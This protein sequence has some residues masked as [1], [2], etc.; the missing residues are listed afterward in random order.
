M[1]STMEG[2]L[3][4]YLLETESLLD[5]LDEMLIADEKIG[6]FS[7]DDV[8]EIFRI[9]HTIKGSS[10]MMEFT[11][12]SNIAHHIE[13]MFFFIRDK[14]MDCLSNEQ[15]NEL[16][17]LMFRSEDFLRG[18]L[19][20]VKAGDPLDENIEEF[21]EEI[22]NFLAKISGKESGNTKTASGAG[23]AQGTVERVLPNDPKAIKFIHVFLDQGIGMENLRA[24]MIVNALK[25]YDLDFRYYPSDMDTNSE[26]AQVIVDDGFFLAFEK[27]EV[28]EKGEKVLREQSHILSYEIVDAKKSEVKTEEKENISVQNPKQNKEKE[29]AP[30]PQNTQQKSTAPV[31]QSL[32]SVNLQKLD[33]LND[34]VGEIVI[35]E[36][37]VTSS[38]VLRMLPQESLDNFMK[39]AR[40]L[41][42]LTDDLQDIAMSLRMVSISGVFQKM[43]RI[44][45]DM[46][47]K[48]G[49]D[50]KLTIIGEDTE[51][52]KTIV[53]S[54][55][56]PLMHIVR[57]SMDHGIETTKEER[58]AA[59]KDAQGE[60][61]LSASHTSSEVIITVEDDGYGMNP[62]KL[63]D[64]A[65]EKGLLYKPRSEYSKKEA[66]G[67][68]ML[69]GFSTNKS[70]TEFS[71]RGVGM[72]VVK[73]NLESVGGAI[74]ISSE[75]GKGSTFTMKIPL[76]LAIMDGMKVN[77]GDT[78]FTIP[79]VNIRQSFKIDDAEVVFDENG[80]EM[81]KRM[82][83][84]YPIVRLNN[85]YGIEGKYTDLADGVLIWVE[86]NDKSCCLFVDDLIGEQ[87]VVVKPLPAYF[88]AF[89]LKAN[90]I[91]GCSILGDGN[92]CI[93]LDVLG[94]YSQAIENE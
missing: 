23:R 72:D 17:D 51:V 85:F 82:D 73:K 14:G 52:D 6:D 40:Q 28:L 67:L 10:A 12:I 61:I 7:S 59:G 20:K 16:F 29:A 81:V 55:Q 9:M 24:F 80:N 8:N 68:I 70:V 56:D 39:S 57:N 92:I 19:E 54:L 41:R 48:L 34:L 22:N 74:S 78:I 26:T 87:Q 1:D 46:K 64:K 25:E 15:K 91:N 47:Q 84:F 32:I 66:L 37:M 27:E 58:I 35:T 30:Q 62:E 11:P 4:T 89:D 44:V 77:V 49:K 79:I 33:S 53:D 5:K 42:K 13:D 38:P 50:V 3:D 88:N 18:A 43:N 69:P 75:L 21:A 76:T 36:S 94:L 90:G 63:L 2:M 65:E 93:I 31:K 45:R 83:V 86:A 60:L 71:G